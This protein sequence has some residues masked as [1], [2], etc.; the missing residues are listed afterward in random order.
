[1]R[2]HLSLL[3]AFAVLALAIGTAAPASAAT[4]VPSVSVAT[5]AA[6]AG[7]TATVKVHWKGHKR[8]SRRHWRRHHRHHR[9]WR[10]LRPNAGIQFYFGTPRSV[11]PRHVYPGYRLPRV[12]IRWCYK[13]YRSYRAYDNTFQPY[14]GP[15]RACRSPY[16]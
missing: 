9:H 2:R 12:H 5:H 1:M 10:H 6:D 15:R 3:P 11:R 16:L 13:R 7:K 8:H 14:H 4:R